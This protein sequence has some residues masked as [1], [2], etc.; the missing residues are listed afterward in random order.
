MY[1]IYTKRWKAKPMELHDR[2]PIGEESVWF[3]ETSTFKHD[4]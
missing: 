1:E 4:K 3:K 2:S